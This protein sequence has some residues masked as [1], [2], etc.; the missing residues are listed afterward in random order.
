LSGDGEFVEKRG[1]RRRDPEGGTGEEGKPIGCGLDDHNTVGM[2]LQQ[3]G[4]FNLHPLRFHG[5]RRS[6]AVAHN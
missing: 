6:V 1:G 2:V 3:L 5:F 4:P